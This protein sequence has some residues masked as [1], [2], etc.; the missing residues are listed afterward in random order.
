MSQFRLRALFAEKGTVGL[1]YGAFNF[2]PMAVNGI[3][4]IIIINILIKGLARPT[5]IGLSTP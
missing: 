2:V 3:I 4:I 5:T 1:L